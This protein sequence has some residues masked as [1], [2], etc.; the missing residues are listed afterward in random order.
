MILHEDRE[1]YTT[2]VTR[3]GSRMLRG[4]LE[5]K[6]IFAGAVPCPSG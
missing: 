4:W 6:K 1:R 3:D 2:V 5:T